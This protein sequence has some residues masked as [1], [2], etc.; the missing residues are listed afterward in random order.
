MRKSK[1]ATHW[2]L[3]LPVGDFGIMV[4][5]DGPQIERTAYSI[6]S[7]DVSLGYLGVAFSLTGRS[8]CIVLHCI[9]VSRLM[10]P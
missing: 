4:A 6:E 10:L 9:G 3:R 7:F 5:L 2:R 8:F 1:D